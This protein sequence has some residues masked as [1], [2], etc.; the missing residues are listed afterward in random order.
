MLPTLVLVEFGKGRHLW[1]PLPAFLLWPFWPLAWLLW[2]LSRLLRLPQASR[3]Q[4]FLKGSA[5]LSGLRLE[6]ETRDGLRI[7]VRLI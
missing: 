7:L 5:R 1:L 3:L 2:A 6:I 4:L